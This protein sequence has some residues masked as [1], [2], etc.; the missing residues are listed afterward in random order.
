MEPTALLLAYRKRPLSPNSERVCHHLAGQP[1]R[2]P[3]MQGLGT[4]EP[5]GTFEAVQFITA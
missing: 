5:E 1:W 4:Y 2:F 3:G